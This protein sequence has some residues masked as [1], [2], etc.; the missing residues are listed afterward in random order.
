M[1][2]FLI[3][4]I[5]LFAFML[6]LCGSIVSAETSEQTGIEGRWHGSL[7]MKDGRRIET[8]LEVEA[9]GQDWVV[10]ISQLEAQ[11]YHQPVLDMTVDGDRITLD[12]IID[13]VIQI[14]SGELD[15]DHRNFKGTASVNG[16]QVGSFL[17]RRSQPVQK[18]PDVRTYSGS[19]ILPGRDF[20]HVRLHLVRNAT[21]WLVDVD[22]PDRGISGYPVEVLESESGLGIEI[23]V[24]SKVRLQLISAG[25]LVG[26][27]AGN[28]VIAAWSEEGTATPF[29]LRWQ[30]AG[31]NN[32]VLRPQT[33]VPPL[34]YA[35]KQFVI[36]HPIG[37]GL[38]VTLVRP[39]LDRDVPAVVLISSGAGIGRDDLDDGHRYQAVWAD[40]LARRGIASVRFDDRGI[41]ESGMSPGSQPGGLGIKDKVMDVR[42]VL[43]WLGSQ[44]GIDSSQRGLMGWDRGGIVAMMVASGMPREVAFTVL[45]A[46]PGLSERDMAKIRM[47]QSL[48]ALPF[49]QDRISELARRHAILIDVASDPAATDAE[50]KEVIEPYLMARSMLGTGQAAQI[51]VDQI[52]SEFST[53]G[54]SPYRRLLRIDPR[55]LLP[56]LRSPVLAVT[57]SFD[58]ITPP[59]VCLPNIEWSVQRTSGDVTVVELPGL[60][61]RL[62][63][64][65]SAN[66]RS[67]ERIRATVD[68]SA[69]IAVTD[70][71]FEIVGPVDQESEAKP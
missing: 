43:E 48:E 5:L 32:N 38:G 7:E 8:V 34:P 40:A 53:F 22:M 18:L 62:Q 35:Q 37:H 6:S 68:P 30:K 46:A 9:S 13:D 49:E 10:R 61:H 16:K 24:P 14:W 4:P 47:N 41:G 51:S 17:L 19:V 28:E 66:T 12:P 42:F 25:P 71:I 70:W 27:D 45:L 56:R 52:E 65:D 69:M 63:P 55:M 67:S 58:R 36:D 20:E 60:N 57:G 64:S 54:A 21:G 31:G 11:R 26:T 50:I 23:P 59:E 33:P 2:S 39:R 44:E 15:S 29:L 3:K 1:R